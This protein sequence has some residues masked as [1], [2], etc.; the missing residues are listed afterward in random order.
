MRDPERRW[1]RVD[2]AAQRLALMEDNCVREEW[3]VSTARNGPGELLDSGCTPRGEHRVRIKIGAGCAANTVFVGR[4][5]TG[6]IYSAALAASAPQR[7]WILTRIIWLTGCE[8]GVNR[9]GR[10]DTLRRYI[11]IHGCPD[12]QPIGIPA[13]HGCIRMHNRDVVD[14][15]DRIDAG[16]RVIILEQ[17]SGDDARTG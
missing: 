10:R 4:R 5:P 15:F 16:T 9:G 14:L 12:S 6:E 3:P 1:V 7:D 11:Y 8:R 2:L 13:S 17:V